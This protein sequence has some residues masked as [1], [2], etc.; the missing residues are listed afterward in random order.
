MK[1]MTEEERHRVYEDIFTEMAKMVRGQ[2][3]PYI[4]YMNGKKVEE[5][6]KKLKDLLEMV[7]R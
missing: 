4:P 1:E 7:V 5:S 3:Y 2:M 6:M